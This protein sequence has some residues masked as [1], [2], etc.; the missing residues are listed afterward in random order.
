MS[1]YEIS[2]QFEIL[3][4]FIPD[5]VSEEDSKAYSDLFDQLQGSLSEKVHGLCCVIRNAESMQDALGLEI[6]RMS[7]KKKLLENKVKRLTDYMEYCL[8]HIGQDKVKT[9]LFDVGFRKLPPSVVITDESAIPDLL[10]RTKREPDKTAIK[11]AIQE[12]IE[13][14]GAHLEAGERLVIK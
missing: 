6:K 10:C 4:E 8:R 2:G 12:G 3:D 9:S 13:V 7:N 1:L 11:Q 5:I 14:N